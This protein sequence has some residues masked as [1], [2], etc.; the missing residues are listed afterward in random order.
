MDRVGVNTFAPERY[1]FQQ[2]PHSP[3]S[4]SAS[5]RR[6][7]CLALCVGMP[8]PPRSFFLMDGYVYMYKT[9]LGLASLPNRPTPTASGVVL[10]D[11]VSLARVCSLHICLYIYMVNPIYA[12]THTHKRAR[13][14]T[15]ISIC[16]CV[17]R[18]REMCWHLVWRAC[19]AGPGLHHWDGGVRREVN[20][21]ATCATK[22]KSWPSNPI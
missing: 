19:P 5:T 20:A 10:D 1:R 17:C 18:E 12:H 11:R 21:L 4:A 7:R 14:H 22:E 15:H 9:V 16:V 2:P 13:T 8:P 6:E 3:S